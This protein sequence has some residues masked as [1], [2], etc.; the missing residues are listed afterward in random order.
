MIKMKVKRI[1]EI[2]ASLNRCGQMATGYD[3]DG[4]VIH[5]IKLKFS[6]AVSKN[7]SLLRAETEHLE[8]IDKPIIEY[9][10]ELRLISQKN[11]EKYYEVQEKYA[12]IVKDME[13][14]NEEEREI[15]FYKI[16][17]SVI[18]ENILGVDLA[19]LDFLIEGEL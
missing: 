19:N 16:Q 3:K 7:L 6:Y 15:E 10:N 11:P 4:K 8:K 5:E 18:P 2:W 13:A 9:Q 17:A 12:S 14:F 1:R